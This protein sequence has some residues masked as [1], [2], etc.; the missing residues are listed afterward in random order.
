MEPDLGNSD[1]GRLGGG[2]LAGIALGP[3]KFM[4]LLYTWVDLCLLSPEEG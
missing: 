3:C 1:L 4:G 2:E